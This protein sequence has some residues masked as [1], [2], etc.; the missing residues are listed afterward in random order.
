[1]A[2]LG[3]ILVAMWLRDRREAALLW[4]GF[5]FIFGGIAL[6]LYGRP[7][8]ETDF[9]SITVGNI[10][11]FA[12]VGCFWQGVRVFNGRRP[13]LLP[14]VGVNLFWFLLCLIP[15]VVES[16]SLRVV[17]VSILTFLLSVAAAHELWRGRGEVLASRMPLMALFVSFGLVML[18]RV[19]LVGIAPF[20]VGGLP[21][22][23]VWVGVYMFILFGHASFGGVLFI[24]LIKER[25]EAEQRSFAMSDP[26]TGLLNRRAF[27]DHVAAGVAPAIGEESP[28]AL[29]VLDLD[30]F[31]EVN[32][33]FGHEVGDRMLKTFAQLAKQTM[34]PTDRLYRMGGE[35]FCFVL[36]DCD[37]AGAVAAAERLRDAVEK[38][39]IET[40]AGAAQVTVSI[41]VAATRQEVGADVV[42]A[43]A[44]A[45]VYEAKARGRN[46]VVAAE[47]TALLRV[48]ES[49]VGS[50]RRSA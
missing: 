15:E 3:L 37:L 16:L 26:L 31:K 9:F 49:D 27:S 20:P 17:L 2:L 25:S 6:S 7:A 10:S 30:H 39:S 4:W 48:V 44:D 47:P 1:M 18:V 28:S 29:L 43:A 42:L 8:W 40:T 36:P 22:D 46:R 32:D 38:C 19:P 21:V 41:G 50:T 34:R 23:P 35:E 14:L 11:R 5:P 24:T 33:R 12:A 45:A 13:L